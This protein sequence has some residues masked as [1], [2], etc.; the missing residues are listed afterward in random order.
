MA[1]KIK[2][3]RYYTEMTGNG[4]T[5]NYPSTIGANSTPVSYLHYVNGELFQNYYPIVQLGVQS[6]PGTK[7]YLNGELKLTCTAG[8]IPSGNYFIG[9]WSSTTGQNFKGKVNDVRIYNHA[10]S[11]MEV[12]ELVKVF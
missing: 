5:M 8:T 11:Q 6:L 1:N 7:F 4:A 10:L 12:K 3:F 2:Q 9:S